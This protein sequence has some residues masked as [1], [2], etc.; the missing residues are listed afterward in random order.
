MLDRE[1]HWSFIFGVVA[2]YGIS[3]GLGGG[4]MRVTSDHH[5][6]DVQRV[7]PSVAP[8]AEP[9]NKSWVFPLSYS[10]KK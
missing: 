10:K 1:L 9:E 3:Q 5:W 4:I 6:K 7:Q 2:T 8:V